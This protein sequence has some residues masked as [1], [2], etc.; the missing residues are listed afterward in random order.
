[1]SKSENFFL[2]SKY[3]QE[4]I[5]LCL[6]LALVCRCIDKSH[7]RHIFLIGNLRI[8]IS[9]YTSWNTYIRTT[10]YKLSHFMYMKD[11]KRRRQVVKENVHLH[12]QLEGSRDLVNS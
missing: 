10:Y 11:T 1:M 4:K 6:F 8:K 2:N 5:K 3:D 12:P 9:P 7:Y